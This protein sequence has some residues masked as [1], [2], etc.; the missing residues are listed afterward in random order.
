[1]STETAPS[2]DTVAEKRDVNLS[3][4]LTVVLGAVAVFAGSLVLFAA[5]P[6]IPVEPVFGM[7]SIEPVTVITNMTLGAS[8]MLAG[9]AMSVPELDRVLEPY[10]S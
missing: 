10:S 4:V 8:I 1:M 6:T 9:A 2:P 5:S 7:S 3:S